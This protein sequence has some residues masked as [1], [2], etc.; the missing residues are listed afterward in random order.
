MMEQ[1]KLRKLHFSSVLLVKIVFLDGQ[2]HR[3]LQG[4]L[5][6]QHSS[7]GTV[8]RCEISFRWLQGN[9]FVQ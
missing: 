5:L 8:V 3:K 7:L 1:L 6:T 2:F 9:Y 4:F